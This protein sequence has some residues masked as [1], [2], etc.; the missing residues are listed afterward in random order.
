MQAALHR[1][2]H[3]RILYDADQLQRPSLSWFDPEYWHGQGG[4][5][6]MDSGRGASWKVSTTAGSALLK[7]YLRGGQMARITRDRY[8]FTGWERSRALREWHLLAQMQAMNLPVPQPLAALCSQ[9]GQFYTAALLCRYIEQARRLPV[10]LQ[11][12]KPVQAETLLRNVLY[13]LETLHSAGV[14]HPDMNFGNVLVDAADK[15]WLIDFDRARWQRPGT[16]MHRR[17][18][19]RMQ[20]RLQRSAQRLQ[21]RGELQPQHALRLEQLLRDQSSG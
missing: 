2:D 14:Y 9:Q 17:S 12:C 11:D 7:H 15:I 6:L 18:L 5:T 4:A 3:I 8:V 13:A 16:L 19:P 10:A 20:A 1:Q 21:A